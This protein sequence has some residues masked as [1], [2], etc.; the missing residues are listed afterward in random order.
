M[1]QSETYAIPVS[2]ISEENFV[3]ATQQEDPLGRPYVDKSLG[4]HGRI[5]LDC[6]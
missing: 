1:S 4:R 2:S 3:G 6:V 5:R